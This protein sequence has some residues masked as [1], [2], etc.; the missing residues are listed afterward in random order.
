MQVQDQPAQMWTQAQ[1]ALQKMSA[2]QMPMKQ[3]T[4]YMAAQDA[5]KLYEH[6]LQPNTQPQMPNMD[7]KIKYPDV[8]VQDFYWEPP[9]RMGDGLAVMAD[10]MKRPAP[11]GMC[12]DQD[13]PIR[14][15]G[16]PF[17]VSLG[18]RLDPSGLDL[19]PV[20]F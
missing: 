20:L 7:K 10:R 19:V 12:S 1:A 6:Q 2:M 17:E 3:Q 16:P 4:F 13:A 18:Q 14:Q 15:R 8:K 11:A 5:L 9:Y